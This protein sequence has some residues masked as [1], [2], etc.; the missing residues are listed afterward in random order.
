MKPLETKQFPSEVI[1][2]NGCTVIMRY[3]EKPVP[4][5]MEKVKGTLVNQNFLDKKRSIYCKNY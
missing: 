2:I 5:V 3:A 4:G 1:T